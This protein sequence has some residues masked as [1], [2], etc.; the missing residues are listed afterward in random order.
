[1]LKHIRLFDAPLQCCLRGR[2]KRLDAIPLQMLFRS[3][4]MVFFYHPKV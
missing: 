1:M 4:N 3:R 2:E